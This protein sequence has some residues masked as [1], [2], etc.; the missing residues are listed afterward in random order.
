MFYVIISTD[1]DFSNYELLKNKCDFYLKNRKS[2]G[3]TI[4][5]EDTGKP[6]LC[7]R[8]ANERGL[9]IE[10]FKADW[11]K[12]GK[13]AGYIVNKKMTEIGNACIAFISSYGE[14]KSVNYMISVAR[15]DHL[16]VREVKEN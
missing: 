10:K 15:R 3:I 13:K 14:N 8:Y 5:S 12:H 2:E 6:N 11:E 7:D 1:R 4:I 9:R 16:L